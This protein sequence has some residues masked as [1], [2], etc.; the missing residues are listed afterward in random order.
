MAASITQRPNYGGGTI[1]QRPAQGGAIASPCFTSPDPVLLV[2]E[3]E[4]FITT[5]ASE[6]LL[7]EDGFKSI[8]LDASITQSPS[9]GGTIK[10]HS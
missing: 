8:C 4:E 6:F 2:T 1:I 5:E 10:P 9:Q 3:E 7:I